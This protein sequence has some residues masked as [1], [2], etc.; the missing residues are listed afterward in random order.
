MQRWDQDTNARGVQRWDQDT[1]AR[2]VQ[3]RQRRADSS[4]QRRPYTGLTDRSVVSGARGKRRR[5]AS[6]AQ[7]HRR[8]SRR[9]GERS[10][11]EEIA[12]IPNSSEKNIPNCRRSRLMLEPKR[13]H[14]PSEQGQDGSHSGSPRRERDRDRNARQISDYT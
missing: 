14:V 7:T 12:R 13:M 4:T 8:T 5:C 11:T 10:Q 9:H 6:R 1:N 3:R 2:G